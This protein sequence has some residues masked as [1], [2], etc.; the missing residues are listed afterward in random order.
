MKLSL[1]I[2]V[3]QKASGEWERCGGGEEPLVKICD[4]I[5]S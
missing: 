2:V 4:H 5:P 1:A 3:K